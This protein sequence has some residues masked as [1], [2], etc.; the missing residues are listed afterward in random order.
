MGETITEYTSIV[1]ARILSCLLCLWGDPSV[2]CGIVGGVRCFLRSFVEAFL[3][4]TMKG[5]VE[6][7]VMDNRGVCGCSRETIDESAVQDISACRGSI[8]LIPFP[9][10]KLLLRGGPRHQRKPCEVLVEGVAL[11]LPQSNIG[12]S[13]ASSPFYR[14]N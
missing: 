11:G 5:M 14:R 2:S 6:G 9:L 3:F 13:T 1:G 7:R 4:C 10:D 12:I 8:F